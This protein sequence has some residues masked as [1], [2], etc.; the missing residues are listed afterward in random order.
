M[1]LLGVVYLVCGGCCAK[2]AA[3]D[4][5]LLCE[6]CWGRLGLLFVCR[7][8]WFKVQDWLRFCFAAVLKCYP[9]M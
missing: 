1:S 9:R 2:P 6:G 5:M 4:A 8:L 3:R 7:F